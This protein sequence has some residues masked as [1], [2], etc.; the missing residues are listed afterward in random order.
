LNSLK[1]LIIS[2]CLIALVI[3]A[4]YFGGIIMLFVG[5]A[6]LA[7][8]LS[9]VV[10]FVATRLKFKKRVF[11]VI[12]VFVLTLALV[13][14]IISMLMPPLY[15]QILSLISNIRIYAEDL[16]ELLD[17]LMES[18]KK[19][20][21][22]DGIINSMYKLGDSL[23][24]YIVSIVVNFGKTILATS[25]KIL[26]IVIFLCLTFYFLLDGRNIYNSFEAVFPNSI[27]F[28]IRRIAIELDELVWKYMK[29]RVLLSLGM[30]VV[31]LIGFL[32]VGL[33]YALLLALV[34][35]FLDFIPY[36]GSIVAG[37]VATLSALLE[38]GVS[39][40]I[41][42]M[43]FFIAL[44][45]L[46]GNVV[47]PRMQAKAIDMHPI[48]IIFSLLAC[49]KLWGAVGMF[50]SVPIAGFVKV[51]AIEIRDLYRSIGQDGKLT[52]PEEP[53]SG[54]MPAFHHSPQTPASKR[55]PKLWAFGAKLFKRNGNEKK[56]DE[57]DENQEQ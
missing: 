29:S 54:P 27:R 1:I 36:I 21:L 24:D 43:I 2:S 25:L 46:E 51:I 13:A 22:P 52:A 47:A 26:D 50:F 4:W 9:P 10:D 53:I 19:L 35:F 32:C 3:A 15:N 42:I 5:A 31:A 33:E 12:I 7:F 8:M 44:Q 11:A 28:R 14:F 57:T 37:A 20:N 18:A 49:N 23:E 55:W 56:E 39:L 30:F 34:A 17:R 6:F 38:G 45:Q 16:S 40:A 48:A 41:G